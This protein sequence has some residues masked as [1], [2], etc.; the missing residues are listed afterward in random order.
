MLMTAQEWA[1]PSQLENDSFWAGGNVGGK[2]RKGETTR[3]LRELLGFLCGPHINDC[4]WSC[5][6]FHLY[7]TSSRSKIG[8]LTT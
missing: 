4:S 5:T 3:V 7:Q 6:H 2:G 8:I 1:V